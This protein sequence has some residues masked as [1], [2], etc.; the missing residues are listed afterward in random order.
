MFVGGR[1]LHPHCWKSIALY[2]TGPFDEQNKD[3]EMSANGWPQLVL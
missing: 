3:E 2:R 1:I